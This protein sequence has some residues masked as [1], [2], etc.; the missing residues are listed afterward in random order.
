MILGAPGSGKTTT[1][2]EL[3]QVLIERAQNSNESIPILLNLSSWKDDKQK[4]KDWIV[5]DLRRKYGVRQDIG[6]KWLENEII[7]PFL[8]GLDE[9]AS[10]RQEK[11]VQRLN[12][13]LKP[14]NW[15]GACVVCSRTEEYQV[16][17]SRLNLNSSITLQSL[18]QKQIQDYVLST[19]GLE[20]WELIKEDANLLELAKNPLLLNIILLSAQE[21]FFDNWQQLTS[22]EKR[23]EHL[24]KAYIQRM[25]TRPYTG[26][27]PEK[28]LYWLSWLAQTLI[29]END[30]EFF[31]EKMQ[32]N[33]LTNKSEVFAYC[34]PLNFVYLLS[35]VSCLTF[36]YHEFSS[37]ILT[38]FPFSF[39]H[40]NE[41]IKLI[42][43]CLICG[44][45]ISLFSSFTLNLFW[46]TKIRFLETFNL[47]FSWV[48]AL[49]KSQRYKLKWILFSLF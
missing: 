40:N 19:E 35:I 5:A 25:L 7:L 26:K 12:E 45:I 36:F 6:Q 44:F 15:F 29:E 16:Y 32:P 48:Q 22:S 9:L 28:T 31:I 34:L 2:L 41:L 46:L 33:W 38:F 4:I 11:C 42:L 23:L 39:I 13:F 43:Y 21:I 37:P 10:E 47:R 27:K 8:D 1:L 18:S 30:T 24:F 3:A 14:E 49:E 17:S 20:F